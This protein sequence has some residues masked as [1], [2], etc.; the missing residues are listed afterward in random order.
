MEMENEQLFNHE[1]ELENNQYLIEQI[2]YQ[3]QE[4]PEFNQYLNSREIVSADQRSFN[5]KT[6]SKIIYSHWHTPCHDIIIRDKD[7]FSQIL[8]VQPTQP[9]Y[10]L[11]SPNQVE[12]LNESGRSN[13]SAIVVKGLRSRFI[14]PDEQEILDAGLNLERIMPVDANNWRLLYD[15]TN[16]EIWVDTKDTKTLYKYLG[17]NAEV[18]DKNK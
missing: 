17:F 7:G 6:N 18:P 12:A 2:P 1:N 10:T 4:S 14:E 3:D 11:L 5:E 13:S 8:H 15:P 16:N 9:S